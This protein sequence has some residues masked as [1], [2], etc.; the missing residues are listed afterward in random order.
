M[1]IDTGRLLERVSFSSEDIFHGLAARYGK[2]QTQE[3]A[4]FQGVHR[5]DISRERV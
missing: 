4:E 2:N 5:C 1:N 3:N